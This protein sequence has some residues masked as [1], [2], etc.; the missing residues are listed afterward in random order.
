MPR[1]GIFPLSYTIEEC[2]AKHVKSFVIADINKP[3]ILDIPK[4][5]YIPLKEIRVGR[6][7]QHDNLVVPNVTCFN[8]F[9]GNV[10]PYVPGI[11]INLP[12][13]LFQNGYDYSIMHNNEMHKQGCLALLLPMKSITSTISGYTLS[14]SIKVTNKVGNIIHEL[15]LPI[16]NDLMD[17]PVILHENPVPNWSINN[18][19]LTEI[20]GRHHS[21]GILLKPGYATWNYS[22]LSLLNP[23]NQISNQIVLYD[24]HIIK[25]QMLSTF[26]GEALVNGCTINIKSKQHFKQ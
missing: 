8:L 11:K 26:N 5:E 1:F 17:K 19:V 16:T 12:M 20:I 3:I 4:I 13:T 9:I 23:V 10:F 2:F 18:Q 21:Q 14:K 24:D 15:D 7:S 25:S 22:Y 6:Y